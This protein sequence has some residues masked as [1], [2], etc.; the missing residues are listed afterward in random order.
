MNTSHQA[1]A[2]LSQKAG[3]WLTDSRILDYKS[4]LLEKDDLTLTTDNSLNLANFLMGK[5]LLQTKH[6][7]LN[8]VDYPYQ[9]LTRFS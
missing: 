8:L 1:K 2:I 7:C 3:R 9:S 4:I 5:P 6:L